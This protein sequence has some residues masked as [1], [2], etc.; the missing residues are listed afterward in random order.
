M[1]ALYRRLIAL[2]RHEP[3]LAIGSY[4]SALAKYAISLGTGAYSTG[5][6]SM[7][8]GNE[9]AQ[10]KRDA[11]NAARKAQAATV[12][13]RA[14]FKARID[15]LEAALDRA[16]NQP[17]ASQTPAPDANA[18]VRDLEKTNSTLLAQAEHLR[19]RYEQMAHLA[20]QL[21]EERD[22]LRNEMWQARQAQDEPAPTT[23]SPAKDPAASLQRLDNLGEWCE[24]HLS[25]RVFLTKRALR[26]AAKSVH[27]DPQLI[28]RCLL[29][30]DRWFVPMHFDGD[31]AA[32]EAW[33][34]FIARERLRDG[35][36]GTAPDNHRT[37]D[38]YRVTFQG[39]RLALNRHLQG[40]S[41]RDITRTFR[42]YYA[43][44]KESNG[45]TV[46]I[47]SLPEHLPNTLT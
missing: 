25:N 42:V 34:A 10:A 28:A 15:N 46:V 19:S 44:D 29:A 17:S 16:R 3:A 26:A 22:S 12:A 14:R 30:L 11:A 41:S 32:R 40:S 35:P 7:S 1:L 4:S 36:V 2:R 6:Y 9:L 31:A 39:R 38:S 23:D 45:G 27:G 47:G 33:L 43:L 24:Q 20:R 37:W 13:L 18:A 5:A 21:R 8:L